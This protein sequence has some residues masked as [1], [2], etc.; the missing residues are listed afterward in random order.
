MSDGLSGADALWE[1]SAEYIASH[2]LTHFA[3]RLPKLR[4][5]AASRNY[6][7]LHRWS[8]ENPE[9]F[10]GEAFRFLG[11]LAEG[12][13]VPVLVHA[14][15]ISQA[16]WFPNL[17][18]N[19]AENL[20]RGD[21]DIVA[22]IGCN[23]ARETV[24]W[25]RAELA[26]RARQHSAAL[27]AHGIASGDRVAAVLNN[28]PEAVAAMLGATGQGAIW[29][30]VSPEFGVDAIVERLRQVAPRILYACERYRYDGREFVIADKLAQVVAAVPSIERVV[31]VGSPGSP[32]KASQ[33]GSW[34]SIETFLESGST[35]SAMW[36]RQPFSHPSFI[37]FTSGT[38]GQP[39]CIVHGAGG[40]LLQLLKEHTL[41]C[42][43]RAGDV[44]FFPTTL[45]WMMW[46]WLAV[47]LAS[48]AAVVLY[49]GS[50]GY[51]NGRILFELA[52]E[53]RVTLLGL[54]SAFI[55]A[56]RKGNLHIAAEHDLSAVRLL[57]A[58]GSIL[59]PAAHRYASQ[60]IVP[61]RPVASCSGGTDIVSCF[62]ST[63][64]WGALFAG[65]LQGA[66][67]GMDVQIFNEHGRRVIGEKGELVCATPMPSMPV[68]FWN[69]ADGSKYRSAY[70]ER[71]AS[72]WA[73]GDFTEENERGGFTIHGR[74]DAVLNPGGV[75]IGT[76]EIY[77]CVNG[78][79]AVQESVAVAQRWNGDQRIVLFVKLRPGRQ[80]DGALKESIRST[81]RNQ[82]SP[83]H[84]PSLVLQVADIPKTHSG[85][86][87]ESAVAAVVNG[88]VV[89]QAG[90]L[91]NPHSLACFSSGS[92]LMSES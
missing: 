36:L 70:F 16:R 54:G 1:P 37:L 42:D 79:E 29:S 2:N 10:W 64:P 47:G 87:A 14:A 4:A 11:I 92:E 51:R 77:S 68:G 60:I 75:R 67:L 25:T 86:I 19:F 80:L 38:T 63:N 84:V 69:D 39:K 58:G 73:H 21:P 35:T 89:K 52:S 81:I 23:E 78:I 17:R 13:P 85:K 40:T 88:Q 22:I 90:A 71:F 72:V 65:E 61:G 57:I 26:E 59:S 18:L 6:R 46:N 30:S 28:V 49:D 82:A 83:R 56:C 45:A 66:A 32:Q 3:L 48:G 34:V 33:A 91:S 62:L 24:R 20:V 12:D 55:E 74:S 7:S 5:F 9:E 8:I 15:S 31:V 41:H 76:A 53:H 43:A 50:P 44:M 27:V